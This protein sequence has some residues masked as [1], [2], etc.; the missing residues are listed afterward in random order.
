MFWCVFPWMGDRWRSLS[1]CQLLSTGGQQ[2]RDP[3]GP[4]LGHTEHLVH[5]VN[6]LFR[7]VDTEH[8]CEQILLRIIIHPHL[9]SPSQKT[10]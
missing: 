3:E 4:D 9:T 7:S 8:K 10:Q 5:I 2:E 1:P 6:N